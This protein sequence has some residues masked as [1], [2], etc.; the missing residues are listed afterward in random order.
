MM[1]KAFLV[2][3]NEANKSGTYHANDRMKALISDPTIDI[4]PK[5]KTSYTMR[6]CHRWMSFSNNPDPNHKLKR[7]DLTFRMSDDKINNVAYF[8]EGNEYAKSIEVAK[9]IYDYF[10]AYETKPK[11]VESDIPEGQYDN[12]LKETQKDPIM[13]FLEETVY[14]GTGIRHVPI[15]TLYE[16]YLDFCRRNH[17]SWTKDKSSFSTRLGMK[18]RNGLSSGAKRM[19]GRKQNVWTFD[20]NLLKPQFVD[21]NIETIYDSDDE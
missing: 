12:M 13:E 6:S 16:S 17:I 18:K 21:E 1:K 19:D 4:Q 14:V 2:V 15:N 20:F 5:G 7:R 10:M 8:N 11:I 3:L 9:A